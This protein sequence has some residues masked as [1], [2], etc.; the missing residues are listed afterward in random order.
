MSVPE[1]QSAS[2]G[3]NIGN[4]VLSELKNLNVPISNCIAMGSDNAPVMLGQKQGVLFVLQ[5]H[6]VE[7]IA[8]GCPCHLINIAA[9][10]A[11]KMLPVSID[12]LLIDLFYCME[13]SVNR[14]QRLT[15]LQIECGEEVR[16]I[17][18]HVCT[19]WLS[20]GQCLPRLTTQ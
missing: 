15:E 1:L 6:Q 5:T 8:L 4:L 10:N 16:K 12:S 13:G 20:L 17:L 14:K 11:A 3:V 18:K 9:Q 7:I 2:T 19:R